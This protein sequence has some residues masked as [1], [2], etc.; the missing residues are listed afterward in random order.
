MNS[1]KIFRNFLAI[2][3]LSVLALT[4]CAP[5]S[6]TPNNTPPVDATVDSSGN[7]LNHLKSAIVTMPDG[8]KVS[9]IV[10]N[11]GEASIS[12]DWAGASTR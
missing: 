3:A 7:I 4:G 1:R 9:C 2:G 11:Q 5:A 8:R 12:C 10:Y 6:S